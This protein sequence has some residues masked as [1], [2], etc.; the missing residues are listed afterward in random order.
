M[1]FFRS[2]IVDEINEPVWYI[3]GKIVNNYKYYLGSKDFEANEVFPNIYIG[4]I[5]SS[6]NK[7]ELEKRGITHIISVINGCTQ[8]YPDLNYKLVHLNDD[9]WQN[10]SKYFEECSNYIEQVINEGESIL[11]HCSKGVSRSV[12]IVLAYLIIKKGYS[13]DQAL[14]KIK[15]KRSIINPNKG[16]LDQLRKLNP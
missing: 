13:L 14:I 3:V 2:F 16:F 4:N 5:N 9:S 12:T 11:V 10:I 15:E 7:D 6:L 1:S 8:N